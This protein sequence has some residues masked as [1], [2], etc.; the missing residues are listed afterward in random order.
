MIPGDRHRKRL[1]S[2]PVVRKVR[3]DGKCNVDKKN[4]G[5]RDLEGLTRFVCEILWW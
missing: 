3:R 5:T 1:F 2:D 4:N